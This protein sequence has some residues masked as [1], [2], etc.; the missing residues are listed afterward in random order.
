MLLHAACILCKIAFWTALPSEFSHECTAQTREHIEHMGNNAVLVQRAVLVRL[1]GLIMTPVG[2]AVPAGIVAL[3]TMRLIV[4]L[5][6]EVSIE[7]M[8]HMKQPCLSKLT[9]HTRPI[10]AQ[11][12]I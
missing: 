9:C 2:E 3:E 5:L 4:K 6:G 8:Q 10:R 11:V 1:T 12:S 7:E